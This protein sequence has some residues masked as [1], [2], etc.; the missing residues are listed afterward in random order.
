[1]FVHLVVFG[2]N[3]YVFG[4]FQEAPVHRVTDL[5]TLP[6]LIAELVVKQPDTDDILAY[7]YAILSNSYS[8]GKVP[9]E[10]WDNIIHLVPGGERMAKVSSILNA[11]IRDTNKEKKKYPDLQINNEECY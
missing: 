6:M 3:P 4:T 11:Y 1:M 5:E 10:D 2:S 7:L 8:A 9:D